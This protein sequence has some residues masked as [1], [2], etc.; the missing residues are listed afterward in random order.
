MGRS[1]LTTASICK[2]PLSDR[3]QEGD[4]RLWYIYQNLEFRA[5]AGQ[6]RGGS[7]GKLVAAIAPPLLLLWDRYK[8]DVRFSIYLPNR[9]L[10]AHQRGFF[11]CGTFLRNHE[12]GAAAAHSRRASVVDLCSAIAHLRGGDRPSHPRFYLPNPLSDRIQEGD[13]RLWCIYR[14][15]KIGALPAQF[16]Q[17]D[18][19]TRRTLPRVAKLVTELVALPNSSR[20]RKK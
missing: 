6:F 15:H 3:I 18:R 17:G 1:L 9:P 8:I 7:D 20:S 10:I 5:V 16:S 4:F 2:I 13:F 12:I 11:L 14:N 19:R